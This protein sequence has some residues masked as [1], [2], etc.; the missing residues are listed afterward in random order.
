MRKTYLTG[1][2]IFVLFSSPARL[3]AQK[4]AFEDRWKGDKGKELLTGHES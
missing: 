2:G 3:M 4:D 1:I